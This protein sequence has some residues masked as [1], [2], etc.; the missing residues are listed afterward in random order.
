M[1]DTWM[2]CKDDEYHLF[3]LTQPYEKPVWDRVCHAV[4]KDWL[5]WDERPEIFLE[6]TENSDSWDAECILTGSVFQTSDGYA[7]TYGSRHHDIEMIGLLFSSD[8][9]IWQKS[10][11]NPVLCPKAPHYEALPEDTSHKAVPWRDAYVIRNN[12]EYEAFICAGDPNKTKTL[13]GC[14]ARVTSSDLLN[15]EYH[16]PIASPECYVDME[17]PQYFE[18][19][20]FHYLLFSTAGIYKHIHTTS[21]QR[22]SGIFY[23]VSDSKDGHY[24]IP[25][26]NM[27]IGSGEGR[28]DCYAGKIIES[29]DGPLLYHHI[30]GYRTAFASPKTVK[31][32]SDGTLYLECWPGL[33]G[34]ES[35]RQIA[36][37]S[38]GAVLKARR[39][40]PVGGWQNRNGVLTGEAG[41]AMSA[42]LF[43]KELDDFKAS[44]KVQ[45]SGAARAGIMFR[46]NERDKMEEKGWAVSLDRE[47]SCVELCIP[48]IQCRTSLR[49]DPLDVVY[50]SVS[51]ESKIE[52]W[53]RDS[54]VEVYINERIYFCFNGSMVTPSDHLP[55]GKFGFFVE[56]GTADFKDVCA[57]QISKLMGSGEDEGSGSKL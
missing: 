53:V 22:A 12:G 34:L 18:W 25:E 50:G 26:D 51:E 52:V 23:L 35:K 8:L 17:V 2:F 47:R 56:K 44:C 9:D 49:L 36:A 16:P 38:P 28:F 37:E 30:C 3:T 40:Y 5:H 10:P 45:L 24:R 57:V 43:D 32:N 20:G 31:Q 7:M 33:G 6:D 11:N 42:W 19:N 46:I 27:L 54:Y 29:D 1:W 55:T 14:I 39:K 4:S 21:R 48:V 13:N 41:P 15:W